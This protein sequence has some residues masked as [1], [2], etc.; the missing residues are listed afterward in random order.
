MSKSKSKK[1]QSTSK[2]PTVNLTK[3]ERKKGISYQL[4]YTL[5]KKRVRISLG[6]I[7]KNT[8]NQLRDKKIKELLQ[9]KGVSTIAESKS[10]LEAIELHIDIKKNKVRKSTLK[11]YTNYSNRIEEAISQLGRNNYN[12]LKSITEGTFNLLAEKIRDNFNNPHSSNN[13]LT[14]LKAVENTAIR[15]G[16]LDKK[17]SQDV[18]ISKPDP[19]LTVQFYTKEELEKIWESCDP[20]YLP[21]FKLIVSTGLRS[22]EIIN[23]TWDKIGAEMKDLKIDKRLEDGQIIWRPKSKSSIRSVP[24]S[25]KAKK[26][27]QGQKGTGSHFI[28]VTKNGEQLHANTIYSAFVSAR[29]KANVADKGAIHALRHTFASICAQKGLSL[30]KIGTYLGHSRDETT[31]IYAHLSPTDDARVFNEIGL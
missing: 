15:K 27:I 18:T 13:T 3:I 10:L 14:F 16:Y 8:A 4:D 6:F 24:L 29:E 21:I 30:Y 9:G 28:F 1:N 17:F 11:S 26:I 20:F 2:I 25:E 12:N 23:L 5:N 22:G 31:R 19:N 7:D